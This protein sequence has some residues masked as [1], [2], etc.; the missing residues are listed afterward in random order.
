MLDRLRARAWDEGRR[1][2]VVSEE[3][4]GKRAGCP[5]F[6]GKTMST[7]RKTAAAGAHLPG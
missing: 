7:C 5:R 6:Q 2:G 3:K 4:I 1:Q